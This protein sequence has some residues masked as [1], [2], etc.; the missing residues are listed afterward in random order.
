MGPSCRARSSIGSRN[1]RH[2][3]LALAD[4]PRFVLSDH[5]VIEILSLGWCGCQGLVNRQRYVEIAGDP[6]ALR[7]YPKH[8][9]DCIVSDRLH[10]AGDG[11]LSSHVTKAHL[12]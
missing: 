7:L 1:A 6:S 4:R 12:G 2:R 10:T 8:V 5:V 11:E 9:R 3:T